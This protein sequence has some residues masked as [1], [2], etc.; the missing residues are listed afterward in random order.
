MSADKYRCSNIKFNMDNPEHARGWDLLT[1]YKGRKSYADVVSWALIVAHEMSSSAGNG[2]N[3]R[4]DTNK[5]AAEIDAADIARRVIDG[6][7]SEGLCISA[8]VNPSIITS[9][10]DTGIDTSERIESNPVNEEPDE[11]NVPVSSAMLGFA[12]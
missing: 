4:N 8:P 2:I 5:M 12:Y 9:G 3:G 6:L 7:K 1:A 11:Y 10:G